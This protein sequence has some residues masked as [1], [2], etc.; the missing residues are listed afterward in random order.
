MELFLIRKI[1]SPAIK[2]NRI[3]NIERATDTKRFL[4]EFCLGLPPAD[5]EV[6]QKY[7]CHLSFFRD[8][9]VSSAKKHSK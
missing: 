5:T 6:A 2:H 9:A 7:R 3:E 1:N 8:P 4:S